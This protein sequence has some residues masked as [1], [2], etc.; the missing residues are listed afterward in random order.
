MIKYFFTYNLPKKKKKKETDQS[1]R[2][3]IEILLLTDI[4]FQRSKLSQIYIELEIYI[5]STNETR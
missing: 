5:E 3:N 4:S 2:G 1:H